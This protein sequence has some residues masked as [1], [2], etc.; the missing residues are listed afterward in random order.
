MGLSL[1][2]FLSIDSPET[3]KSPESVKFG[4]MHEMSFTVPYKRVFLESIGRLF[5]LFMEEFSSSESGFDRLS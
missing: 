2:R 3:G 1:R 5:S 4:N